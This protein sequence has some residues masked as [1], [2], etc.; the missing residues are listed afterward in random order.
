MSVTHFH[1]LPGSSFNP[2]M[3]PT[4]RGRTALLGFGIGWEGCG[5]PAAG[6]GIARDDGSSVPLSVAVANIV[7]IAAQR[8]RHAGEQDALRDAVYRALDQEL[9]EQPGDPREVGLA[10]PPAI[11]DAEPQGEAERLRALMLRQAMV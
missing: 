4:K 8:A 10:D 2:D 11:I 5:S 6:P 3:R 1:S 7:A 9:P